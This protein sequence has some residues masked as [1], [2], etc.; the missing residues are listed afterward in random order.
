MQ[1][2][3]PAIPAQSETCSMNFNATRLPTR[4]QSPPPSSRLDKARLLQ[5]YYR[6]VVIEGFQK[7]T[8]ETSV[9]NGHRGGDSQS[10]DFAGM[11]VGY[12]EGEYLTSLR[13]QAFSDYSRFLGG[14]TRQSTND[15]I[16]E[17]RTKSNLEWGQEGIPAVKNARMSSILSCNSI[18]M[19]DD[20]KSA[21]PHTSWVYNSLLSIDEGV[22]RELYS[23]I[24]PYF[25]C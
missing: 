3:T 22:S 18:S 8:K 9:P 6:K 17:N 20:K 12:S 7:V 16:L 1:P 4:G 10:S 11:D 14:V 13:N 21:A 2:S 5:R 25:P 15:T 19:I 24:L 23:H